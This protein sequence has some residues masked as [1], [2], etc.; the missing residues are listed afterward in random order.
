MLTDFET[1]LLLCY[2]M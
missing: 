2:K 1:L